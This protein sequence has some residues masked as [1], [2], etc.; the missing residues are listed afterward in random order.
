MKKFFSILMLIALTA[1]ARAD[2][3]SFTASAAAITNL[4]NV[5]LL[6]NQVIIS[7]NTNATTV[8]LYDSKSTT[9]TYTNNVYQ[10]IT[11]TIGNITNVYTN[12]L[13][14]VQTNVYLGMQ[15]AYVTNSASTNSFNV[16][17]TLIVP[18]N[19]TITYTPAGYYR[20][21]NGLTVTN[22]AGPLSASFSYSRW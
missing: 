20:F 13:G 10:T 17:A 5:P 19:T 2:S 1:T 7:A 12:F 15:R 18:A 21:M 14:T 4:V 8:Y 6:V 16:V 22:T 9:L 3:V 11:T